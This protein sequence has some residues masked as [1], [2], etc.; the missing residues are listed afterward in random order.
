MAFPSTLTIVSNEV[1]TAVPEE[2]KDS[3]TAHVH[4]QVWQRLGRIYC[5]IVRFLLRSF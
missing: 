5:K 4:T 2:P 3:V 1:P